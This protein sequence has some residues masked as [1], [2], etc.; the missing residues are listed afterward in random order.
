MN[1]FCIAVVHM[2]SLCLGTA[3][4]DIPNDTASMAVLVCMC[5]HIYTVYNVYTYIYIYIYIYGYIRYPSPS[6]CK[7]V[8]IYI[9]MYEHIIVYIYIYINIIWGN[10]LS[11]GIWLAPQAFKGH[12]DSTP[13]QGRQMGLRT[14]TNRFYECFSECQSNSSTKP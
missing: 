10:H 9:Y 11:H 12:K 6:L 7:C 1:E 13:N 3:F 4:R 8:Y 2:V 14:R 5:M